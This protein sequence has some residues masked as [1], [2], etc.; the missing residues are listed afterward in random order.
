MQLPN[1]Y[2]QSLST[3][4]AILKEKNIP[5]LESLTNHSTDEVIFDHL[6][7]NYIAPFE[8]PLGV[9]TNFVIDGREVLIPMV[10]EEPSVIAAAS[11]AAKLALPNGFKTKIIDR[12]M[13]GQVVIENVQHLEEKKQYILQHKETL[14]QTVNHFRPSMIKRGGGVTDIDVKIF[15]D[16][17]ILTVY[18]Y[19]NTVDAMGANMINSLMEEIAPLLEEWTDGQTLLAILSNYSDHC[20]V[21]ASCSIPFTSINEEIAQKIVTANEYAKVDIV[22]A[23]THNKGI[24][25]GVEAVV[26][27]SGNDTRAVSAAIHAYA[28]QDGQYK[29][30]THY[31]IQDE[32]LHAK[33][34]LPLPIGC[35]GGATKVLPK[36]TASLEMMGVKKATD[37]MAIIAAVGLAQNIAALKALVS[38]GIQKGH[39][40]LQAKSLA[41]QVG[42]TEDEIIQVAQQL[43]NKKTM[44]EEQARQILSEIRKK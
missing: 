24:M 18:F 27:A 44:T 16:M 28:S 2:K 8:Q 42:A 43:K 41:L 12:K 23:T 32:R 15:H 22:R 20:L 21:E 5:C 10:N 1:F 17:N 35:V 19:V 7:E 13:T 25:N 40:N 31:F 38:E 9:A 30:L 14:I 33:I 36:A 29:A 11:H 39:M 37:L 6:V 34:T 3:R 26:R 4:R